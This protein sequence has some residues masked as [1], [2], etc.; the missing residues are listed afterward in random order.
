[1]KHVSSERS[2][3][4]SILT[5]DFFRDDSYLN[6]YINFYLFSPEVPVYR[7]AQRFTNSVEVQELYDHLEFS[8]ALNVSVD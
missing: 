2:T 6:I 1:M 5:S 4:Y 7:F 8:T 3:Y